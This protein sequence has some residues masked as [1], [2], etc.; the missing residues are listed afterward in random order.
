MDDIKTGH[1]A[2]C[3]TVLIRDNKIKSE[4]N[5]QPTHIVNSLTELKNILLSDRA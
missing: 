1:A 5:P 3:K 2:G 4:I